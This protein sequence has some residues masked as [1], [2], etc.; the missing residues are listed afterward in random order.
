MEDLRA[1]DAR[2]ITIDERMEAFR[3]MKLP[4]KQEK[5]DRFLQPWLYCHVFA[6]GSMGKGERKRAAKELKRFFAQKDLVAILK[7]AGEN[8]GFL[9]EAHLFDSADKYLTICRDDDGFGRKLF[10]LVRMKSQEKEEKIIADVY[11]SMI[12]LL[13]QLHD[14]IESRAMIRSLDRACRSLYPQRLED[15]EAASGVLKDDSLQALLDPFDYTTQ[16]NDE[17]FHGR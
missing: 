9:M 4:G 1:A 11:R 2:E 3:F 6:A 15:M 12:P 17:S 7:D 14:L 5:G 16:E 8:S 13:A 10:G